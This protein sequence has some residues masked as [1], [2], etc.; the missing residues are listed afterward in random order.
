VIDAGSDGSD[1][2][3]ARFPFVRY[4]RQTT[5]GLTPA[6]NEALAL[7]DGE[8][9]GMLD[10]D[11]LYDPGFLAACVEALEANPR[12]AVAYTRGRAIDARGNVLGTLLDGHRQPARVLPALLRDNF[13]MASFSVVR[14]CAIEAA[15]GYDETLSWGDDYDLFLRIALLGWEF[16][17]VPRVLASRRRHR[18]SLTSAFPAESLNATLRIFEKHD[19]AL[20]SAVGVQTAPWLAGIDYR[21]GRLYFQQGDI[22]R[23]RSAFQQ[24]TR[25]DPRHVE[26]RLYYWWCRYYRWANGPL[27]TLRTAKRATWRGLRA[28][29]SLENRWQ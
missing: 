20:R 22:A 8:Y 15:G 1:A 10:S 3:A 25:R 13:V 14:R 11:D 26:A 9:V 2:V 18:G 5:K 29:G 23:A 28:L 19:G 12:A 7:S 24:A 17:H 21:L 4:V 27:K 16:V 6:R